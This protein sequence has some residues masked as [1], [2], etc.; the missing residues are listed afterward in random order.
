M[1]SFFSRPLWHI[2][3]KRKGSRAMAFNFID[4]LSKYGH[5]LRQGDLGAAYRRAVTAF[6]GQLQQNFVVL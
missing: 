5:Q 3:A 1:P 2:R 6:R 4:A